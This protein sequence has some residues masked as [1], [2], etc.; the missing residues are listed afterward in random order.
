MMVVAL[1]AMIEVNIVAWVYTVFIAIY[2]LMRRGNGI[3]GLVK[4]C[5]SRLYFIAVHK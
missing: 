4:C 1:L 3:V 2:C 5:S